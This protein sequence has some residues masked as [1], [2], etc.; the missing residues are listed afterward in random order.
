MNDDASFKIIYKKNINEIKV[1]H[2]HQKIETF[3]LTLPNTGGI[4]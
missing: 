2:C 1:N 3:D 4:K